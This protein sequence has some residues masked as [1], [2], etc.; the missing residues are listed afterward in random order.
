MFQNKSLP[1]LLCWPERHSSYSV[2]QQ[3][4]SLLY[5]HPKSSYISRGPLGGEMYYAG[6]LRKIDAKGMGGVRQAIKRARE[7]FTDVE[8]RMRQRM[9]VYP[10]KLRNLITRSTEEP[11]LGFEAPSVS[12]IE[13]GQITPEPRP[14]VSING[15]DVDEKELHQ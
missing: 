10:Q 9:R 8:R 7:G 5:G 14:I 3:F 12:V 4:P 11:G 13:M 1:Q 6:E 15:H 2:Q